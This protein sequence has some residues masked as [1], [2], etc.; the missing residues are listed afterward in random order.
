MARDGSG[1][2]SLPYPTFTPNT[3]ADADEITPNNADLVTAMAASIA[4]DGQTTPTANLPMGGYKHTGVAAGSAADDY[5]DVASVQDGSY[6][7][8]G[9]AGGTADAIT[10]SPSPAITAYTTGTE[11]RWKA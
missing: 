5:A 7:W 1:G 4:K 9:T 8:C 10:L 3:L 6:I 2:Y 11:F